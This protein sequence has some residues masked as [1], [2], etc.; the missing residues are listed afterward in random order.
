MAS[1]SCKVDIDAHIG[2]PVV[3][4]IAA[5][6]AIIVITTARSHKVVIARPSKEVVAACIAGERVIK[7]GTNNI[8]NRNE[9]VALCIAAL[10]AAQRE[11]DHDA[12]CG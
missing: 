6:P 2:R 10:A 4:P 12:C 3:N 9:R 8:L 11:I 5:C 7:G 1:T